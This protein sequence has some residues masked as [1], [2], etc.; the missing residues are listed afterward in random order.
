MTIF[1]VCRAELCAFDCFT[2]SRDGKS[3]GETQRQEV[4][5]AA[6]YRQIRVIGD[7]KQLL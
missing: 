7:A 1:I 5:Q 6:N 4:A 2:E 3:E